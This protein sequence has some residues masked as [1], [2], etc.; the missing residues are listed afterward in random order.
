[1]DKNQNRTIF[2]NISLL[3][4]SFTV[5]SKVKKPESKRDLVR[6]A[7]LAEGCW[8]VKGSFIIYFGLE[9]NTGIIQRIA[10]QESGCHVHKTSCP[11]KIQQQS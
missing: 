7:V 11:I 4:F 3:Y 9:K 5:E 10:S 8:A 1:M 6:Y 2:M